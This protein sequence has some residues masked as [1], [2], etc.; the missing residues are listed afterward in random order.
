MH[1]QQLALKTAGLTL[2]YRMDQRTPQEILADF[3]ATLPDYPQIALATDEDFEEAYSQAEIGFIQGLI[4][5]P[6][7]IKAKS[8]APEE[9]GKSI[10]I[11]HYDF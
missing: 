6:K 5:L 10:F 3:I 11:L 2:K 1:P 8:R 4:G 7:R 9:S